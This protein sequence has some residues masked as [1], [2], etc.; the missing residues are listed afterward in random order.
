MYNL[1]EHSD[2]YSK[3]K[4]FWEVSM[5]EP[6]LAS[7][8]DIADFNVDIATSADSFKINSA[9]FNGNSADLFKIKEKII[10]K[11]SSNGKIDA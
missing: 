4:I 9:D 6:A 1:I 10:D 3:S 8:D 11:T 5:D 7:N 2:N